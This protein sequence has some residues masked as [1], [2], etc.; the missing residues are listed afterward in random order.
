MNDGSSANNQLLSYQTRNRSRNTV[1]SGRGEW[2]HGRM[3]ASETRNAP[4]KRGQT[5]RDSS[6][7]FVLNVCNNASTARYAK[8]P[9]SLGDLT[10]SRK[11]ASAL[12]NATDVIASS[13]KTS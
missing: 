9:V 7:G 12:R 1:A 3:Y 13:K 5:C 4:R 8:K 10:D 11:S 6:S 2:N